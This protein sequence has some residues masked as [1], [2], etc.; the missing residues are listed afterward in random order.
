MKD[1]IEN[2]YLWPLFSFNLLH[3]QLILNSFFLKPLS[4]FKLLP[5][6]LQFKKLSMFYTAFFFSL[7]FKNYFSLIFSMAFILTL[8]INQTKSSRDA[9]IN[10]MLLYLFTCSLMEI[11]FS[12]LGMMVSLFAINYFRKNF[13]IFFWFF[14]FLSISKKLKIILSLNQ[15]IKSTLEIINNITFIDHTHSTILL[16]IIVFLIKRTKN[17]WWIALFFLLRSE[18]VFSP[19]IYYSK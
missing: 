5:K 2:L 4:L 1:A 12:M 10:F 14:F 3:L 8:K 16:F 13:K 17:I 18:L 11:D 7:I 9:F 6:K 15:I 19:A